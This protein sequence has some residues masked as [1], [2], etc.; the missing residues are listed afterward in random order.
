MPNVYDLAHQLATAMKESEEYRN[1]RRALEELEKDPA[2]RQ[3]V[4]DFQQRSFELQKR[5][6]AG[7]HLDEAAVQQLESLFAVLMANSRARDFQN[8]SLRL[9][10]M[11]ADVQRIMGEAIEIW[12]EFGPKAETGESN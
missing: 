1:Y 3:M 8:A 2:S 10:T 11:V 5:Q 4:R 7:Q 12:S 9:A 6:W